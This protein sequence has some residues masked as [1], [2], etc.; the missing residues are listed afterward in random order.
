MRKV[1]HSPSDNHND[2]EGHMRK[3]LRALVAVVSILV[4]IMAI[5]VFVYRFGEARTT[6]E[7]SSGA[8]YSILRNALMAVQTPNDFQDQF[9][10]DRL[11]AL[12]KGSDRLLAAQVLD[13]SGFAVWKIPSGSSYFALPN[14]T[15]MRGG[16]SA[17][18]SS[19]VV[20]TTPLSEGMKL[21]ALYATVQRS[22]ISWAAKVPLIITAIWCCI[23][24][25]AIV[26]FGKNRKESILPERFESPV[27]DTADETT[28]P[29]KDMVLEAPESGVES[30]NIEAGDDVEE[31][32]QDEEVEPAAMDE[33]D[34]SAIP[35][36]LVEPSAP[37][38]PLADAVRSGRSFEDSLAKLEEEII[39]WSS[40]HPEQGSPLPK[41]ADER[42]ALGEIQPPAQPSA[43]QPLSVE[44]PIAQP[45]D[46]LDEELR[47]E[48]EEIDSTP[49]EEP[50]QDDETDLADSRETLQEFEELNAENS[51]EKREPPESASERMRIPVPNTTSIAGAATT[52]ER[53]DIASLPMPL[54][55][56]DQQLESRLS[57]E[58]NRNGKADVSLMLIHCTVSSRTDPAAVALA[59]TIK[60]YI[61]SK[62]LIFELYKGA[63]AVVLPSVDLGGALKM[64]EDLADVLSATLSLYK[65]IEGEAPVFIGIS[66][67]A[68]R[69]I[70]AY[71]LYRE[72]STAVHKA[73][74]GGHSRI[75]A[76]RPKAE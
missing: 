25:I 33:L 71:K 7:R 42:K 60:D 24:A 44:P 38:K 17:P 69:N 74:S 32:A 41:N 30:D 50:A 6:G 35:T 11:I 23:V 54:S 45:Q 18:E 21:A 40:R 72:A 61:G 43:A 29:A 75:L 34:S 76:F 57:E 13:A 70:D 31:V 10:R 67:R 37:A 4:A 59:V 19:T 66:A 53:T 64:S 68:D 62:E 5:I 47:E 8:E 51:I 46:E 12:Y 36:A 27:S 14:D 26:L 48:L 63:F 3:T 39:E 73:Y 56:T 65:D 55:L 9:L 20:F 52:G 15:S 1:I 49:E 16:Y 28:Q 2:Q 58:M 22:D